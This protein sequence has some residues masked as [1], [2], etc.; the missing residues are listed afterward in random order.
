MIP[1]DVFI[2]TV[3]KLDYFTLFVQLFLISCSALKIVNK[4]PFSIYSIKDT[5]SIYSC[6]PHLNPG[7]YLKI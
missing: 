4:V 6:N 5:A 3:G 7:R 1:C 2:H